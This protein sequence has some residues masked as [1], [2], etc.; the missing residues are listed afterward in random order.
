MQG[1]SNVDEG[2]DDAADMAIDKRASCSAGSLARP[3]AVRKRL[4]YNG[5]HKLQAQPSLSYSHVAQFVVDDRIPDVVNIVV[6][7]SSA[8]TSSSAT[9]SL[10]STS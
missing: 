2:H 4:T 8:S 3:S 6:H 7:S 5:I 9:T 10:S 1:I